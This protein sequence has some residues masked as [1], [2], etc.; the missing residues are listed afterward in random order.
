MSTLTDKQTSFWID[1][2]PKT[3]YPS[4]ENNISVDVAIVGAGIVG[5]T[6]AILLKRA[7]K[8]VAVIES[9]EIVTGVTG[10]TTAKITS[11]HQLIYADLIKEIGEQKARL[12]AES[13][14]MAIEW[15]AQLVEQEQIYCDFSRQSAYTFAEPDGELDK[16]KDEVNAALKLGLPATLVQE[17]SLPFTIAGAIKLENQA[18]FHVRKYLL[19]LAR[20]ILG[21]GSH[22]FEKTR[23]EKVDE[24][25]NL[26]QIVTNQG[27]IEAQDV[28]VATNLPILDQ[29]LFFAKTYPKRSYIIG[30]IIDPAKAPQ[31]MYIG[32]GKN[33]HSIR[34]TPYE[35]G[36]LL[37]VGG[38]GHKVGT[39]NDTKK[40][41][42]NLETYARNHFGIDSFAYR[43]S[44][45]DMT[46]FDKLPFIGKLTPFN[47]HI[48]VATGFSLWGM[49]KGTMAGI[50]LS[51]LVLGK[52][53]PYTELYDATRAT[54][55][56]DPELIKSNIDVASRWVGDRLKGIQHSSFAEVSKGEGKL[57]TID[58]E[59]VAA[60][61]DEEG[62][63]HAVSAV[64]PH[65][66]CIVSWNNGE[67]SWDCACHGSRFGCD[68]KL[69][70]GPAV[71]D[72]EKIL[73]EG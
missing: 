72:L 53:N 10:Y 27:I 42:Q 67:K 48:Y 65:L 51:D 55:F 64:C 35:D 39:V 24:K 5:L 22:I 20:N 4:L 62:K 11:L 71:K 21:N 2:T 13:N 18:Q 29:G 31:G 36:L 14:Q 9:R 1:S 23:V 43:W 7:G 47:N 19:H 60:Y 70:Q 52:E 16:I 59:K 68:G 8:T 58:D 33:S 28:I 63:V 49:S 32:S 50:L 40:L 61:R 17:T 25:D 6:A 38:E 46:S 3:S 69:I 57:I 34:T 44:N 30:A 15:I 66:A 41:Y 26:C 54:P 12:Y 37:L 45:Q 56:L 73:D